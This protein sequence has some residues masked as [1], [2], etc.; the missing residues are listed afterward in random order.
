MLVTGE[1]KSQA[2]IKVKAVWE[3]EAPPPFV[4]PKVEPS[5]D[6]EETE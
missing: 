6:I 2:G 5:D 4:L 3:K 1:T